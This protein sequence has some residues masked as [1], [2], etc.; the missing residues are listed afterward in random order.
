MHPPDQFALLIAGG[1]WPDIAVG[2]IRYYTSGS[3]AAVEDDVFF[4]LSPYLEEYAPDYLNLRRAIPT[5]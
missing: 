1:D 5:I 2:G 3:E 4:D